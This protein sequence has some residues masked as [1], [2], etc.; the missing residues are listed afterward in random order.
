MNT[1]YV[2]DDVPASINGIITIGNE[3]VAVVA[4]GDAIGNT[5]LNFSGDN[6]IQSVGK[7]RIKIS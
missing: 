4:N 1:I 6:N 7:N 5:V 2:I 3:C